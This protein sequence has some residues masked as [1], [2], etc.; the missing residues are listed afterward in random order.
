MQQN[1]YVATE[2]VAVIMA[3][4]T[5]T[6]ALWGRSQKRNDGQSRWEMEL[7]NPRSTDGDV[8]ADGEEDSA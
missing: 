3:V 4:S 5:V 7:K 8:A 6:G 1:V 2:V